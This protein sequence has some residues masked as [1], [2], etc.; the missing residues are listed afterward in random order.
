MAGNKKSPWTLSYGRIVKEDQFKLAR[1]VWMR[2]QETVG[3]TSVPAPNGR[4]WVKT[5]EKQ[6]GRAR[7]ILSRS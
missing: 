1:P 5:P 6:L 3:K 2:V 4:W 7:S